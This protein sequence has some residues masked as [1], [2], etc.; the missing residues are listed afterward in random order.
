MGL[1]A[2]IVWELRPNRGR[3][4]KTSGRVFLFTL[5]RFA[6]LSL[7]QQLTLDVEQS[8]GLF[9]DQIAWE[10]TDVAQRG[11]CWVFFCEGKIP[12]T[13][14]RKWSAASRYIKG[15]D[16]YYYAGP[17]SRLRVRGGLMAPPH[18]IIHYYCNISHFGRRHDWWGAINDF[19][20]EIVVTTKV[21]REY[22]KKKEGKEKRWCL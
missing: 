10:R 8:V 6:P 16:V 3:Q 15:N 17:G 11:R 12:R 2:W 14:G 5:I 13:S 9:M 7:E 1:T 4:L 21:T 19:G 18:L 20:L 22:L